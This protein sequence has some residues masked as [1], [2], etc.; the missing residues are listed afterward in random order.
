MYYK[1]VTQNLTSAVV[2]QEMEVQYIINE[3]VRAPEWLEAL[4]FGP[5][6]FDRLDYALRYKSEQEQSIG[7]YR[8]FECLV[9]GPRKPEY[10][11]CSTV[12]HEFIAEYKKK[13]YYPASHWPQGTIMC[14]AVM[15][16][17]EIL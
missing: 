11:L 5:V 17:N 16:T 12:M 7:R 8:L 3:F 9:S 13:V 2:T 14:D 15:L 1:I 6:V 10:F 4:G